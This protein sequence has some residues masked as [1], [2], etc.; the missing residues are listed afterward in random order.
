[1]IDELERTVNQHR[2]SIKVL[3]NRIDVVLKLHKPD[4]RFNC[5]ECCRYA[6][7]AVPYPCATAIALGEV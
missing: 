6:S 7:F 3:R 5:V 2:E 4:S 1:V